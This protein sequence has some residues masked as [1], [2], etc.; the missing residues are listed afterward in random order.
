MAAY[1][2]HEFEGGFIL[3]EG[4][5]RKISELIQNRYDSEVLIFSVYRGDSYSYMTKEVGDV[6]NEDNDDWRA[7]SRLEIL[8]NSEDV[9]LKFNFSERNFSINITGSNRDTV[10]LLFSDL[11]EYINSEVISRKQISQ[12]TIM[13]IATLFVL[14]SLCAYLY[15]T[16][17]GSITTIS[18]EAAIKSSDIAEKLNYLIS[19][20]RNRE[21]ADLPMI[22]MTIL[23]IPVMLF[24]G[25]IQK[26][27]NFI[28]PTNQFLFGKNIDKYMKRKKL[29][30]NIFWVVIVGVLVSVVSG[31]LIGLLTKQ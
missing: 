5:L 17:K 14:A 7:I 24:S 23:L 20:G 27:I 22:A 26:A 8:I 1:V 19:S 9:N 12:N 2:D 6:V 31:L 11:K 16:T 21:T 3:D 10:F 25:Q 4:K 28:F 13:S 30:S 15:F 29:V 18:K